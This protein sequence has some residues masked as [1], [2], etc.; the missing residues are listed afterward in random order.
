MADGP[1][2]QVSE[3]GTIV[4][5]ASAIGGC[6]TGL[7]AARQQLEPRPPSGKQLEVFEA[8][9]ESERL[10]L[11]DNPA[12]I[13][14]QEEVVLSITGRI[15][16]VGHI[17]GILDENIVEIKSQSPELF[18]KWTEDAWTTEPLWAKY[19]WQISC[20]MLALQKQA[21]IVRVP[22]DNPVSVAYWPI[23]KPF[24]TLAEIRSRILEVE[25]LAAQEEPLV[26]STPDFFCP[27]PYLHPQLEPT[28]DPELQLL[29]DEYL[30][31]KTQMDGDKQ[32]LSDVRAMIEKVLRDR[33]K[34]LLLSGITVTR[35]EYE[36]KEHTVKASMATRL[37]VTEAKK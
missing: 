31:L 13:R 15:T 12:V 18:A 35:S 29:V 37:T 34:V 21:C 36:I 30:M 32:R 5:R 16:V 20:Y 14:Q 22:R 24:H 10:F 23:D 4:Y 1:S 27:Y 26:C 19:A 17:D 2:V 33:P 8:G 7:A 6:L 25:A 3:D 9:N 28:D 11:T